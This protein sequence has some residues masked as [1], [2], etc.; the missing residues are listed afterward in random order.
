MKHSW[1]KIR[2]RGRRLAEAKTKVS[3]PKWNGEMPTDWATKRFS[4]TA[5]AARPNWNR[6]SARTRRATRPPAAARHNNKPSSAARHRRP[7]PSPAFQCRRFHRAVGEAD[8]VV[9]DQPQHFGKAK[10]HDHEERS[11]QPQGNG[12]NQQA[13]QRRHH[14]R[15]DHRDMKR[16]FGLRR[17][18][19]RHIGN[20]R[21]ERRYGRAR[22][23][24]HN[25]R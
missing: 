18:Q 5:I 24:R 15:G 25:R 21:P 14:R 17:Q 6:Q 8:P 1:R 9:G 23:P 4:R 2:R 22:I 19:G 10:R 16:H 20:R 7:T 3:S 13:E 12:A 11:A